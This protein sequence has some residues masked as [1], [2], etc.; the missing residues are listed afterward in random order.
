M[1]KTIRVRYLLMEGRRQWKMIVL[2][3]LILAVIVTGMSYSK[4]RKAAAS[5][6]YA[7]ECSF[8]ISANEPESAGDAEMGA[9]DRSISLVDN[10][11]GEM[12]NRLIKSDELI[13]LIRKDLPD[14]DSYTDQDIRG[15]IYSQQYSKGYLM[16]VYALTASQEMSDEICASMEKHI[17]D[18]LKQ[19]GFDVRTVE[20]AKPFGP[21][22]ITQTQI[23][24]STE[25]TTV[26]AP[27]AVPSF[28]ALAAIKMLLVG[29][30]CGIVMAYILVCVLYI[31]KDSIIY[32]GELE[33]SGIPVIGV[34]NSE[35][36]REQSIR[37]A[38]TAI[39]LDKEKS[40]SIAI[41][42]Y[43]TDLET[44]ES[45]VTCC[46]DA[47][48]DPEQLL[49]VKDADAAAAYIK[50]DTVKAGELRRL[51]RTIEDAGCRFAGVIFEY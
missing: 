4:T 42:G 36:D 12:L 23:Q 49:K 28:G 22:S 11:M 8:Q 10:D 14:A 50:S 16:E 13:G 35:T 29:F 2:I 37:S 43:G 6:Q 40:D 33:D 18:Y 30:V 5:I 20:S 45:K 3:G 9:A 21:A 7:S 24:E 31:L 32:D 41:V 26:L 27:V 46:S 47:R 39:A 38:L 19:F 44:K 15:C 51:I 1:E 34:V 25:K 48:K 17:G